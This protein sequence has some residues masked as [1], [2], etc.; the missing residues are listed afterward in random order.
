[1]NLLTLL[2]CKQALRR[3]DDYLDAQVSPSE[4]RWVRAHLAICYACSGHFAFEKQ[5]IQAMRARLEADAQATRAQSQPDDLG[6]RIFAALR[7]APEPAAEHD[8]PGP[9]PSA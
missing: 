1:M 5:F 8:G 9:Q 2:S 7:S 4:A 6:A 3:M